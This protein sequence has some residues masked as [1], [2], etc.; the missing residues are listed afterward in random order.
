MCNAV[1]LPLFTGMNLRPELC[2]GPYSESLQCS[3]DHLA[4][5][6]GEHFVARGREEK[7]EKKGVA[8]S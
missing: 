8:S 7:W 5:F 6:Q 3:P 2:P 4:G 1:K